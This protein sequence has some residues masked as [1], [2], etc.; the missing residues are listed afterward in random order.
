[1]GNF[2][3]PKKIDEHFVGRFI[4]FIYIILICWFYDERYIMLQEDIMSKIFDDNLTRE[5]FLLID[6]IIYSQ[7]KLLQGVF[8]LLGKK[9]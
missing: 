2:L 1:M 6:P 7:M 8:F 3:Y 9:I 4:I 5:E